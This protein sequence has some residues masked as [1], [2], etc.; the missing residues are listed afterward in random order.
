MGQ[1]PF[2]SLTEM[3][4]FAV[5][6]SSQAPKIQSP[7]NVAGSSPGPGRVILPQSVMSPPR[8]S[9]QK[10][11]VKPGVSKNTLSITRTTAQTEGYIRKSLNLGRGLQ[12]S[13][14][15]NHIH[16]DVVFQKEQETTLTNS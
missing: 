6:D 16:W 12:T 13:L 8:Y 9:V 7:I 3:W 11:G 10:T 2:A 1:T 5:A 4:Q 14:I 15:A